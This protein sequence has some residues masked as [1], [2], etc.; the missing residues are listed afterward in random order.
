MGGQSL[1]TAGRH[2]KVTAVVVNER[3]R[4]DSSDDLYGPQDRISDPPRIRRSRTRRCLETV[5]A[6][7]G[8][9]RPCWP[10]WG[11]P[12]P[13]RRKRESGMR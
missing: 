7:R 3:S 4:A 6:R 9:T 12:T 10:R 11:P 1:V 2:P 8:F 5:V 13:S